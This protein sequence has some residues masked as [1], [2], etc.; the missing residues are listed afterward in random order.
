MSTVTLPASICEVMPVNRSVVS[1]EAEGFLMTITD[2]ILQHYLDCNYKAYLV[3]KGEIGTPHDYETLMDRLAAEYRL[4][5]MATFLQRSQG[6]S[7]SRYRVL[8]P[9]ICGKALP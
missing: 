1:T 7:A 8:R 6:Q 5:A 9:P 2:R 4:R 3:L